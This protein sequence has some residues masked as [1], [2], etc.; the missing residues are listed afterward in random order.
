MTVVKSGVAIIDIKVHI[1]MVSESANHL[2][3]Y[4]C[5]VVDTNDEG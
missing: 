5:E 3:D 1:Y 4:S 2:M